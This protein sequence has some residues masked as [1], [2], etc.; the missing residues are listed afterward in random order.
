MHMQTRNFQNSM[1]C[2]EGQ[3]S[4]SKLGPVNYLMNY[5][6]I[7]CTFNSVGGRILGP[8]V[9]GRVEVIPLLSCALL[10]VPFLERHVGLGAPH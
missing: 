4:L 6:V 10:R 7:S 5:N 2:L 9:L 1:L 3:A 8:T